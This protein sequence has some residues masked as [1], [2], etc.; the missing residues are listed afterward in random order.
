MRI[1]GAQ[2]LSRLLFL[3]HVPQPRDGCGYMKNKKKKKK[4]GEILN[5]ELDLFDPSLLCCSF[6]CVC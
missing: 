2:N 3:L 6:A 5:L 1:G 4:T